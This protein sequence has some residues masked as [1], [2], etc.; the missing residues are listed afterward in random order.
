MKRLVFFF[1]LVNI[2]VAISAIPTKERNALISIYNNMGGSN[3]S[4]RTNWLGT[5]GTEGT[6]SGV[7]VENDHVV[8]L[9]LAGNN[10]VGSIP[11]TIDSLDNLEYLS[12]SQDT[13]TGSIPS[14]LCNITTLKYL[15]LNKNKLSG[16]LPTSFSNLTNLEILNLSENQLTGIV[17][18]SITGFTSLKELNLSKNKF[19]GQIPI[20]IS[21][22]TNL[23]KFYIDYNPFDGSIPAS[24]C[25]LT[26]L[27][28]IKFDH[29][30]LSGT[31][32][33][34][35]G[36]LNKLI[37]LQLNCNKLTGNIPNSMGSLI[38][39]K[40]LNLS[41]NRIEGSIPASIGNIS[42]LEHL[43]LQSDS[44]SGTIPPEIYSCG[45][46]K[47]LSLSSNKLTGSISGSISNLS[48]LE[49]LYLNHN[50]LSG[51]I[52]GELGLLKKIIVIQLSN[53]NFTGSIP[54]N[55]GNLDTLAEL[56]LNT[57]KL[58][59]EI[60]SSI[61]GIDSLR[62]LNL[63]FNGITGIPSNIGSFPCLRELYLDHNSISVLPVSIGNLNKIKII[64]VS[65]NIIDTL[66]N[67]SGKFGALELFYVGDN[68]F[69]FK[70][71]VPNMS[72]MS[73][74]YNYQPQA[75][76][77]KDTTIEVRLGN[78]ASFTVKEHVANNSYQ[79]Y[80]NGNTEGSPITSNV[81]TKTITSQSDE[82]TY[83]CVVTNSTSPDLK[84][85]TSRIL[86]VVIGPPVVETV[87]AIAV[88]QNSAQIKGNVI[89]NH[90]RPV[91]ER[92]LYWSSDANPDAGDNVINCGSGDG[93]FTGNLS[94]L[95]VDRTYYFCSFAKNSEGTTLGNI[96]SF[97]TIGQTSQSK[98][99]NIV[100]KK[101]TTNVLVDPNPVLLRLEK[102]FKFEENGS[103]GRNMGAS[104]VRLIFKFMNVNI[105]SAVEKA[106]DWFTWTPVNIICG[107]TGDYGGYFQIKETKGTDFNINYP[108]NF[109]VEFPKDNSF[110]CGEEI[111]IK[112]KY[113]VPFTFNDTNMFKVRPPY[114][115]TE[116][117]AILKNLALELGIEFSLPEGPC[118]DWPYP[119]PTWSNPFRWCSYYACIPPACSW[120]KRIGVD[121]PTDWYDILDAPLLTVCED[122]FSEDQ[123]VWWNCANT[124]N[125][126]NDFGLGLIKAY[127]NDS[128]CFKTPKLES[129]FSFKK[130]RP[131]DLL[132]SKLEGGTKLVRNGTK[133][134]IINMGFDLINVIAL[135]LTK[136]GLSY[137]G[138]TVS[139]KIDIYKVL[140]I[141]IGDFLPSFHVDQEHNYVLTPDIKVNLD[142]GRRMDFK[143]IDPLT[144]QIVSQGSNQIV[145][146]T[147]GHHLKVKYPE[148]FQET[149]EAKPV[150]SM[151][152]NLLSQV[153]HHYSMQLAYNILEVSIPGIFNWILIPTKTIYDGKIGNPNLI[154]NATI[155]LKDFNVEGANDPFV[156]DPMKPRLDITYFNIEN[157]LNIGNGYRNIVYKVILKNNG[158]VPIFKTKLNLDLGETFRNAPY[159]KVLSIQSKN[160][161]PINNCC[162]NGDTD[163]N[164]LASDFIINPGDSVPV[165][166]ALEV[167]PEL[168]Q[169]G[170]DKCFIPVNYY[171]N[172]YAEGYTPPTDARPN[173][174]RIEDSKQ[175]CS[176]QLY[177]DVD[178]G[179]YPIIANA[180]L[181]AQEIKRLSDY[182]IYGTSGVTLA[183]AFDL[184]KGN[185]GTSGIFTVEPIGSPYRISKDPRVLGDLQTGNYIYMNQS[186]LTIDYLQVR[187]RIRLF[188]LTSILRKT[189]VI[190]Q[191]S[192]CL[193][194][195]TVPALNWSPINSQIAL[196]INR[197]QTYDLS[198]G[199]YKQVLFNEKSVLNLS[200]GTYFFDELRINGL[201]S[202]INCDVTNGPVNI[203]VRLANLPANYNLKIIKT[204]T[205]S[206]ENIVINYYDL[207]ALTFNNSLIQ[208][209]LN[210]PST[211]IWFNN[212][213]TLE[214]ACYAKKVVIGND[215]RF[216]YHKYVNLVDTYLKE[217][218]PDDAIVALEQNTISN[219]PNPFSNGTNILFN[220]EKEDYIK[221]ELYDITGR[222]IETI[223]EGSY[224]QGQNS[225]EFFPTNLID[226][227]YYCV[228]NSSHG[229]TSIKLIHIGE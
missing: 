50:Q 140:T 120:G 167:K 38:N 135:I 204:G 40:T 182:A 200:S 129:F 160:G 68:K 10:V 152:G 21:N 197:N 88:T 92:G 205:G 122:D 44:L 172:S 96:H 175:I 193:S 23:K 22:L 216:R 82:G 64:N 214:G 141:D 99:Y 12:F 189:G 170:A 4:D 17:L 109:N 89:N 52:P 139:D 127:E 124:S 150:L 42:G 137:K 188:N 13:L 70:D 185:M 54:T 33:T 209:T 55:L 58:T 46:L 18:S 176:N 81:F 60:P 35:I 213:S 67:F 123:F 138:I 43:Y 26:M 5:E 126:L 105:P 83:S 106:L 77:G 151:I 228:L 215:S 211:E 229:T 8:A 15:F 133:Q 79:W 144:N 157:I 1:L 162:Y 94:G 111:L 66:P 25:N 91:T 76:F 202:V 173:G 194:L 69:T 192:T 59:G 134:N 80:K 168:A 16:D 90:G 28:E 118:V 199:S 84:L 9:D 227:V 119:C 218:V 57:N 41:E 53:N 62:V 226:G 206:T 164:L 198:P 169:V 61:S 100:F 63:S 166:V 108:I 225:L 145:S 107:L 116:F 48:K 45:L 49:Y 19:T 30:S 73:T 147:P 212:N 203:N 207:R 131:N 221:L 146:I 103:I 74:T 196:I 156:L 112:T 219:Y 177:E 132:F 98:D 195:F 85:S 39:L 115:T 222:L 31:I 87:P 174:Y 155:Q 7:T 75:I 56:H 117:G 95:A 217:P 93:L 102:T 27:E 190:N 24:I 37:L 71:I 180:N 186:V 72:I 11:K 208:G 183:K 51:D 153:Y 125:L 184:S 34:N 20:N 223:A 161:I 29:D 142:L 128:L 201:N 136:G 210:A 187:D 159:Y 154:E 181:G 86:L 3:W 121:I 149:S 163:I 191:Y 36:N 130:A 113:N 104:M 158:D 110:A 14:E 171:A 78:I 32:P 65:S 220:L 165:I 6:W 224:P 179:N 97:T 101:D 143:I 2:Y 114:Y 178:Q 47:T 148:E